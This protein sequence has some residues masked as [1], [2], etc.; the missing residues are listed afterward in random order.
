MRFRLLAILSLVL[1]IVH[2]PNVYTSPLEPFDPDLDGHDSSQRSIGPG[3]LGAVA[4]ESSICSRHGTD[5]LEKGG[6]AA[7]A[8]SHFCHVIWMLFTHT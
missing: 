6:N 4:S 7:D 1:V 8:V 2:L 3:K 5:I